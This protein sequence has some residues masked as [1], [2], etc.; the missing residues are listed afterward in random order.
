[1]R[2]IHVRRIFI[3]VVIAVIL[4]ISVLPNSSGSNEVND[5]IQPKM[6]Q[7][8][9][10]MNLNYLGEKLPINLTGITSV[11]NG[12]HF[13]LFGGSNNSWDALQSIY[14]GDFQTFSFQKLAIELPAPRYGFG[15]AKLEP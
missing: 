3:L 13:F 5:F 8:S 6:N 4:V 7:D 15:V 1:M 12:S 9:F 10:D 11:S 14:I 2:F